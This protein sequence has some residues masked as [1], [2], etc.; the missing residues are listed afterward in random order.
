MRH[1]IGHLTWH[2]RAELTWHFGWRWSC[3]LG[4]NSPVIR[5]GGS[6]CVDVAASV[7][8]ERAFGPAMGV[9][10]EQVNGDGRPAY[11][12]ASA[13]KQDGGIRLSPLPAW[14]TIAPLLS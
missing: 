5:A 9:V 3:S 12:H 8:A 14:R 11:A 7:A 6:R 2:W 4:G 10:A 1:F 13:G